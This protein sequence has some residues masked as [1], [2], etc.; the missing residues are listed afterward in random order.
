VVKRGEDVLVVFPEGEIH[1]LNDL[2]Q[3][4]KSGAVA[5]G[6]QAVV[7]RRQSDPDWTAYLARHPK[8]RSL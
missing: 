7:S 8:R 1:Y 2:V 3:P 5:I 4:F 6:M